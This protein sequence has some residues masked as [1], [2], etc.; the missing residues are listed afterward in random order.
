MAET[1]VYAGVDISKDRL[2]VYVADGR[3]IHRHAVANDRAGRAALVRW[4]KRLGHVQVVCEA[5]GGWSGRWSG[6]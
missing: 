2:D 1:V 4:L 6:R 3:K 5:S